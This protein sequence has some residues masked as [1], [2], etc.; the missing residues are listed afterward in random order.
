LISK[1]H[2]RRNDGALIQSFWNHEVRA[3]IWLD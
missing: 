3:N 2:S 1:L